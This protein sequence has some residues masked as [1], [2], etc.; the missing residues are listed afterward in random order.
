[1]I[2]I[3]QENSI[4]NALKKN[5]GKQEADQKATAASYTPAKSE[6]AVPITTK[7]P[8]KSARG[9]RRHATPHD[10]EL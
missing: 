3:N 10:D 6:G 5:R 4:A 2:H 1:V 7:A 8:V 9:G